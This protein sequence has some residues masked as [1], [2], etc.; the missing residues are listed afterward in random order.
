MRKKGNVKQ[1]FESKIYYSIDGC[2][3]W[4]GPINRGGYGLLRVDGKN[5][6]SHR[7][8]YLIYKGDFKQS[9]FVCHTCDNRACVNP[10][11]LFLGT[12]TDNMRDMWRKQRGV[13]S[14]GEK[15]GSARLTEKDVLAIRAARETVDYREI[16]KK[17][18]IHDRYVY[19]IWNRISLETHLT[20]DT[21]HF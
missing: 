19:M 12:M 20:H 18:G 6:G 21:F 5:I 8:S 3:Y 9:L 16:A 11:H 2:W 13:S 4:T 17:Y 1:R 7:L 10:D 14:P 15:S